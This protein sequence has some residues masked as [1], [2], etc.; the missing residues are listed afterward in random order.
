MRDRPTLFTIGYEGRRQEDVV[1][2]LVAA[3]IEEV[4]DVRWRPLSRKRGL[5]KTPLAAALDCVAIG[6]SH[7]RR[8]GTP[9]VLMERQR[10]EGSYDWDAYAAHLAGEVDAVRDTASIAD[11]RRIALLCYEANPSECHRL[12]VGRN[13]SDIA[14]LALRHL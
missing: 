12:L 11:Q 1:A 6:Y 8:L 10:V 13:V 5:S 14:G 7:D 3:G 9:P 4:V 2:L